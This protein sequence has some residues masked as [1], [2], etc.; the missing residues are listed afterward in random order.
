MKT[1]RPTLADSPS[2]ARKGGR[3]D[4]HVFEFGERLLLYDARRVKL[5]DCSRP[6]RDIL[7]HAGP[8]EQRL[9]SCIARHGEP[10]VAQACERLD[11]L[12]RLSETLSSCGGGVDGGTYEITTLWLNITNECNLDCRYCY[13][14][15]G[16]YEHGPRHMSV[17]TARASIDFLFSLPNRQGANVVT[18]AGGEPLLR[19]PAIQETARYATAA[20]QKCGRSCSFRI[21]T[22]GTIMDAQILDFLKALPVWV[23]ISLDGPAEVHDCNRKARDGS[24]SYRRVEA[25]LAALREGGFDRFNVRSTLCRNGPAITALVQDLQSKNVPSLSLRS[26]MAAR[27]SDLR[28]EPS[29][30]ADLEE[31]YVQQSRRAADGA[32]DDAAPALPDDVQVY[33]D[34]LRTGARTKYYCGAGQTMII[35]TPGGDIYPCP[36]LVSLPAYRMGSLGEGLSQTLVRQFQENSVDH[37]G[38][39]QPCWARNLC[40]GGCVAQAWDVNH[41]LEVPDADECRI[42]KAKIRGAVYFYDRV[43]RQGVLPRGS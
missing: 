37:K 21:L 36:S 34:R 9:Q 19:F 35:V 12:R 24:G 29:Q 22:N 1:G 41:S 3:E 32:G 25:T 14:R 26:V 16:G 4:L 5:Y 8:D 20:A 33:V 13:A 23:Q 40:G 6:E 28:L 30:L 27:E 10:A 7:C 43:E 38:A 2:L 31:Y 15:E 11:R 42:I 39:C 18:F 17:E